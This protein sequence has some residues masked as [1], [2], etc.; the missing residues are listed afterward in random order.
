[1]TK[2]QN[3]KKKKQQLCKSQNVNIRNYEVSKIQQQLQILKT[4][5][6]SQSPR[7]HRISN[8]QAKR[9]KSNSSKMQRYDTK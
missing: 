7:T 5:K 8:R 2:C 6:Q 4:K 1:M 9:D 3:A